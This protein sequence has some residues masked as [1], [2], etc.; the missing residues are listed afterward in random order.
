MVLNTPRVHI[1]ENFV[2]LVDNEAWRLGACVLSCQ[3][4]MKLSLA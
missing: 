1:R 3:V 4:M 2:R